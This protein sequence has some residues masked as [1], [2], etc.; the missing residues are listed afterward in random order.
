M[1][2]M[3]VYFIHNTRGLPGGS[4]H[5][6]VNMGFSDMRSLFIPNFVPLTTIYTSVKLT[7]PLDAEPHVRWYI[8]SGFGYKSI[9]L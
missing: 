5:S 7:E 9:K 3:S 4:P 8:L 6:L 2:G 1:D